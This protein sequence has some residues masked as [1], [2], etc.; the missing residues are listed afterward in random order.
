[1]KKISKKLRRQH[2]LKQ[3]IKERQ[4]ATQDELKD[5]L[6]NMG[7]EVTQSSLS[8][9]LSELGVIKRHGCYQIL[10]HVRPSGVLPPISSMTW[11]G[12]N[13]LVIKTFP[14]MAPSM[15]ALIDEQQ[16]TGVVGTVAGD[17]TL[18]IAASSTVQKSE[19]EVRL[20]RIFG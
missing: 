12:G 10:D 19:L 5:E 20:K 3:M 14:S 16:V 8:R 2:A 1:M 9:D 17:D 18:F 13:L 4:I 7:I 11:A 6:E 15:G